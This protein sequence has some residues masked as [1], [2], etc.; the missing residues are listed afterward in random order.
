MGTGSYTT[1]DR[2]G[3]FETR[4]YRDRTALEPTILRGI[5]A[6][7]W[8]LFAQRSGVIWVLR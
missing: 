1:W 2:Q 4:P 3:G 6:L 8:S 7:G 5:M